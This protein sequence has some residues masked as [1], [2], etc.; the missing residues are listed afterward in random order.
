[1]SAARF[2]APLVL[3]CCF[4]LALT[5]SNELFDRVHQQQSSHPRKPHVSSVG[6][7]SFL[8]SR[9]WAWQFGDERMCDFMRGL[10][11]TD[12]QGTE[13]FFVVYT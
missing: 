13:L 6:E 2:L 1:M 3:F 7:P 12:L 11:A 10:G 5:V 8:H 9:S 4:E